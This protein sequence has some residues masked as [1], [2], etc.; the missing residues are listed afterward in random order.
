MN[1]RFL[2][3][4]LTVLILVAGCGDDSVTPERI[5][6]GPSRVYQMERTALDFTQVWAFSPTHMIIVAGERT[7]LELENGVRTIVPTGTDA[8]W[9]DIWAASPSSVYL[10]GGAEGGS[11]GEIVWYNGRQTWNLDHPLTGAINGV[12]GSAPDD[13]YFVSENGEVAR[14]DGFRWRIIQSDNTRWIGG[15]AGGPDD[16]HVIGEGGVYSRWDGDSWQSMVWGGGELIGVMGTGETG[17]RLFSERA[18]IELDSMEVVG[19]PNIGFAGGLNAVA[20]NSPD[21]VYIVGDYARF[22]RYNGGRY[23]DDWDI[24]ELQYPLVDV[25]MAGPSHAVAVTRNGRLVNIEGYETSVTENENAGHWWHMSGIGDFVVV[26]ASANHYLVHDGDSWHELEAPPP[27]GSGAWTACIWAASAVDIWVA[28]ANIPSKIMYY[29]GI[30]W[31]EQF[32]TDDLLY[33]IWGASPDDVFAISMDGRIYHYD[34]VDWSMV[35]DE[36]VGQILLG[37]WGSSGDDVYAVGEYN[38]VRPGPG[39]DILHYDGTSWS[40]ID[41]TSENDLLDIS[42]TSSSDIVAVGRNGFIVRFD[43]TTWNPE[44]SGTT[45]WLR[46]VWAGGPGDYWAVGQEGTILHYDGNRWSPVDLGLDNPLYSVWGSDAGHVYIGGSEDCLLLSKP[47]R[48]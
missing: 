36:N 39:G 29:D 15:W 17:A 37:V 42:G 35:L 22:V 40:A 14:F 38:P 21:D 12:F 6:T 5:E 46:Y 43:G 27:P 45:R 24:D 47:A 31:H 10:A 3:A 26:S 19:Y 34:G 23:W 8:V 28:I 7:V 11:R 2:L 1:V 48:H 13:V 18:V 32:S 33:D 9:K 16:V 25:S 41:F 30:T 44:N 4:G 20:F